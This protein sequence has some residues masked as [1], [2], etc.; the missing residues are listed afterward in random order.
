[1]GLLAGF[2]VQQSPELGFSI[3][4]GAQQADRRRLQSM[5]AE[6]DFS[7]DLLAV[8]MVATEVAVR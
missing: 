3:C 1:M 4:I 2:M 7:G 8:E 6:P 5:P